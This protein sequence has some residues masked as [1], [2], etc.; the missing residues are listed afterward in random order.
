MSIDDYSV[1]QFTVTQAAIDD[2][3]ARIEAMNLPQ[4]QIP[5][6]KKLYLINDNNYNTYKMTD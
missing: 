2:I 1:K 6:G 3:K 4:P 5:E